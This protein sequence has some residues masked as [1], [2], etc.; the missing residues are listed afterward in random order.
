[1]CQFHFMMEAFA[2]KEHASNVLGSELKAFIE[3]VK[4][5]PGFEQFPAVSLLTLFNL[6]S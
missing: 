3:V 6:I 2:V 5:T 1:M 4:L